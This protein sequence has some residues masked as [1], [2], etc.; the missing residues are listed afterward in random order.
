MGCDVKFFIE[1]GSGVLRT[2]SVCG[3]VVLSLRLVNDA[4]ASFF[5][6]FFRIRAC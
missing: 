4:D 3:G 5:F 2:Y 1:G 6:R